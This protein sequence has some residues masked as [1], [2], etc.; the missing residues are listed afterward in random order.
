MTPKE[1][2]HKN[3]DLLK[4]W[5]AV[6]NEDWFEEV[7]MF[8]RAHMMESNSVT[9]EDLRGANKLIAA[10][11]DLGAGAEEFGPIPGPGIYNNPLEAAKELQAT[12]EKRKKRN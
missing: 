1:L 10:L 7:L 12:Q 6:A 9:T 8:A 5:L 4:K 11:K 3:K 2:L